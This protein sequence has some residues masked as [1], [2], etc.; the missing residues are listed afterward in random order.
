MYLLSG[1]KRTCL[2]CFPQL[3]VPI[4]VTFIDDEEAAS[5]FV[6][7]VAGLVAGVWVGAVADGDSWAVSFESVEKIRHKRRKCF[8]INLS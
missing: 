6:W 2:G 3:Y 8:F 5:D 1:L 4:F 7:D